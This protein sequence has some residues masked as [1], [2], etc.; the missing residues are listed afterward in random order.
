MLVRARLRRRAAVL[1]V[2]SVGLIASEVGSASAQVMARTPEEARA[3]ARAEQEAWRREVAAARR[4][5]VRLADGVQPPPTGFEA[6]PQGQ[7]VA[8]AG[9]ALFTTLKPFSAPTQIR[10]QYG[11]PVRLAAKVVGYNWGLVEQGGVGVGYIPLV[12]LKRAG[13]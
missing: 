9:T 13:G 8:A 12:T 10:L 2:L 4:I 6:A 5:E 7:F 3:N 11:Q 1:A